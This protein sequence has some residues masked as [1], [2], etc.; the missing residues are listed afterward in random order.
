MDAID[1]L[2]GI[3]AAENQSNAVHAVTAATLFTLLV[4]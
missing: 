1:A 4:N 2:Q 3:I